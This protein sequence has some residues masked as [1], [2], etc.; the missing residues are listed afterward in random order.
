MVALCREHL[1]ANLADYIQYMDPE[2]L[3]RMIA[4]ALKRGARL[5]VHAED[6]LGFVVLSFK[7]GPSFDEQAHIKNLFAKYKDAG[8]PFL[9]QL[10]AEATDAD[11]KEASDNYDS[12]AWFSEAS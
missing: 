1:H 9:K 6:L 12:S 3:D 2:I 11:W 8:S 7:N 5:G 10:T 4:N